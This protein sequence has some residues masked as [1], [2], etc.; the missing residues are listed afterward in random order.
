M[1]TVV[2]AALGLSAALLTPAPPRRRLGR[3]GSGPFGRR[4]FRHPVAIGCTVGVLLVLT[5]T[6]LSVSGAVAAGVL[7]G[8]AGLRHRRRA[9]DRRGR[10]EAAALQ[11]ALDV[12]VAELR[13]G[14][15]PVQAVEAAAAEADHPGVADGLHAVAARA[16][17]GADVAAGLDWVAESSPHPAHWRRLAAYW[18]LANERGLAIAGLM[19]AAQRDIAE[20]QRFSDRVAAGMAGARASAAILAAL[21][22]LGVGLGQLIGAQPLRFLLT[23]A[24]GAVLVL[25]VTLISVGLQWSDRITGRAGAA[26]G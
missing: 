16:R 5:V 10:D 12:L 25:G 3:T 1:S 26:S 13:I 20:R 15:H 6:G 4:R 21:P 22:A 7:G 24:G 14:A 23:G 19:H 2:I 11:T 18:Q 8:T 9:R 17:L